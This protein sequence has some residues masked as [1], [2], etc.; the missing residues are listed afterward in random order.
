MEHS[1]AWTFAGSR[2][3]SIGEDIQT[4]RHMDIYI[5]GYIWIYIYI[6]GYIWIDIWILPWAHGPGP[7]AQ[8]WR[9]GPGPWGPG[10]GSLAQG[11]GPSRHLWAHAPDPWARPMGLAHGLTGESI[12]SS[13]YMYIYEYIYT[14]IYIYIYINIDPYILN[15][16]LEIVENC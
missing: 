4:L 5:Y 6:Y 8:G 14:Y 2:S 13:I 9:R 3:R 11:Q 10:S 16:L 7:W 1:L 12:Y 15:M